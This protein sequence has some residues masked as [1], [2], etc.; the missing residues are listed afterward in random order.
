MFTESLPSNELFRLSGVM[1]QH[2]SY[3]CQKEDESK[4][5]ARLMWREILAWRHEGLE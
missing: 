1:S 5:A 2:V 3:V 4:R